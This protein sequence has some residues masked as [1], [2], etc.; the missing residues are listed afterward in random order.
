MLPASI[1][2]L[3]LF[4]AL[5]VPGMIYAIRLEKYTSR[6]QPSQL[7]E[8]VQ[9]ILASILSGVLAIAVYIPFRINFAG[10]TPSFQLWASEGNKYWIGHFESIVVLCAL[11]F[12]IS[13]SFGM[14]LA[15]AHGRALRGDR[16]FGWFTQV[17]RWVLPNPIRQTSGWSVIADLY[18]SEDNPPY[19]YVGCQ[20]KDGSYVS[21]PLWTLSHRAEE[22]Q[23]RDLVI[24]APILFRAAGGDEIVKLETV[25]YSIM[26]ASDVSRID[27][28]H[29]RNQEDF[30]EPSPVVGANGDASTVRNLGSLAH[31]AN[32]F[33]KG[34][35]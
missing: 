4:V 20:M 30:P 25:H 10:V 3:A 32:P 14:V 2:S 23:N 16:G 12:L 7:R 9:V 11:Y 18:E 6:A 31:K 19:V 1:A 5:L 27:I 24:S 15:E 35:S 34:Q 13:C 28:T 26:S 22:D 21:G 33:R 8:L 29:L 17:S